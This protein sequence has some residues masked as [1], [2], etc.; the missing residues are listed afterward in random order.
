[1]RWPSA[2]SNTPTAVTSPGSHRRI[3]RNSSQARLAGAEMPA[4]SPEA[5]LAELG[6]TLPRLSPPVGT[7]VD[8]VRTGNLLFLAGKGPQS[9]DGSRPTGKVGRDVSTEV[10]YQHA[11]SVGLMLLAAI[12]NAVGSLDRVRR[13]VKV[14]GMVKAHPEITE[15][16]KAINGWS[17]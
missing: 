1:M 8:A 6:L 4:P 13:V 2:R 14:F 9:L 7:Y 12:K 11:R 5:R 17:D 16:P 10:A 3:S 15:Q